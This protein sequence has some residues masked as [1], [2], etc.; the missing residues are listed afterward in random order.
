MSKVKKIVWL[1]VAAGTFLLC[2]VLLRSPILTLYAHLFTV[3]NAE[4]GADAI[5]CL[6]GSR[7]TRNPECLRLWN[8]GYAQRLFATEEKPKNKEFNPVELMNSIPAGHI[9]LSVKYLL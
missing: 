9:L 6:S 8:Q 4:K 3:Q 7:Q 2:I 5:I 1:L